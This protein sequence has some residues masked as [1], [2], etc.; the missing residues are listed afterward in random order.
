MSGNENAWGIRIP[1]LGGRVL[2]NDVLTVIPTGIYYGVGI[3]VGSAGD[4]ALVV[5]NRITAAP[6]GVLFFGGA[7]GKYRD[8]LT[9]GVS[10]PFQGGT[11]AGGNN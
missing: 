1:S 7:I 2:D 8:N 6:W 3:E 10:Q 11:D 9:S 4:N 5:G